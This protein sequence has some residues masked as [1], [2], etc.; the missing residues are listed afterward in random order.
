MSYTHD[1][2]FALR[3]READEDFIADVIRETEGLRLR[4]EALEEELGSP[5]EYAEQLVPQAPA[6]KKRVGPILAAS[7]CLAL[8]WLVFVHTA[9]FWGWNAKQDL[10]RMFTFPAWALLAAGILGQFLA[11]YLRPTPKKRG[12]SLLK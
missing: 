5:Y 6:K 11:D 9:H 2:A 12:G 7:L 10:G 8:L 1:L 4:D 3:L